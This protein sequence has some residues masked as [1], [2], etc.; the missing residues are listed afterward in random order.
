MRQAVIDAA[1]KAAPD[2]QFEVASA[3]DILRLQELDSDID[4]LFVDVGG[5]SAADGLFEVCACVSIARIDS[6]GAGSCAV[7]AAGGVVFSNAALPGDQVPRPPRP[8][9]R[10]EHRRL[11]AQ[12]L[13]QPASQPSLLDR[14]SLNAAVELHW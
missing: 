4:V 2:L 6:I 9:P 5:I 3:W 13:T 11:A 12:T 1:R 10:M 8:L 7:S 14:C